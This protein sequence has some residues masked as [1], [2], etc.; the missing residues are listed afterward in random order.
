METNPNSFK[1]LNNKGNALFDLARYQ[2]AITWLDKAIA[3]DPKNVKAITVK[4]VALARL[5]EAREA[6]T[7]LDKAL[8]INTTNAQILGLKEEIQATIK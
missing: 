6:M 3:I 8:I 4:G 7:W 5:G 2:E 1:A